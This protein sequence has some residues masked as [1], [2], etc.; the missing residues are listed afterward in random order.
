MEAMIENEYL[1][2]TPVFDHDQPAPLAWDDG[3]TGR[4]FI[5]TENH[6]PKDLVDR[7]FRI[8]CD[9]VR[10]RGVDLV[11]FAG[12]IAK[13]IVV[14]HPDGSATFAVWLRDGGTI[15]FD[16]FEGELLIFDT[17]GVDVGMTD[18]GLFVRPHEPGGLRGDP[19][20][21]IVSG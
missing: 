4:V 11:E 6:L 18:E 19:E 15:E 10:W 16:V 7:G 3:C 14:D 9:T 20:L 12:P 17:Y 2:H 5:P 13:V 21:G 8:E 1:K